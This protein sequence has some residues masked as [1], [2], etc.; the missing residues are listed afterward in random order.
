MATTTT[1]TTTVSTS[2]TTIGKVELALLSPCLP[3]VGTIDIAALLEGWEA[4]Y[5]DWELGT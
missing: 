5:E 1:N 3:V 2:P 4:G